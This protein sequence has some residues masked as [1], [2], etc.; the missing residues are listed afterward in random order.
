MSLDLFRIQIIEA[1]GKSTRG[2][3]KVFIHLTPDMVN[4]M[5]YLLQTKA[6]AG[7][8]SD[9]KYVFGRTCATPQD[10]CTAM[11]EVAKA[12]PGLSNPNLIR[13]RLLRRYLATSTQV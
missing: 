7:V 11:R 6:Y 3:R 8:K 9:N 13:T 1:R 4:G 12:C 2:V 5:E 10:G